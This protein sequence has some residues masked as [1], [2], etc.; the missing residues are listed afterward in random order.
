MSS[1]HA[2]RAPGAT[3]ASGL[4]VVTQHR[5]LRRA[6]LG[7]AGLGSSSPPGNMVG[8]KEPLFAVAELGWPHAPSPRC[9]AG[10]ACPALGTQC[11]SVPIPAVPVGGKGCSSSTKLSFALPQLC[12]GW[13]DFLGPWVRRCLCLGGKACMRLF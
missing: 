7:W 2:P 4:A 5:L 3:K 1:S 12:E 9:P 6:C 10:L 13:P 11:H 8:N